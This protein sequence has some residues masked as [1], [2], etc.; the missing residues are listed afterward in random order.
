MNEADR[1]RRLR[2]ILALAVFSILAVRLVTLGAYPLMD[3]TEAR[4]GEIARVML[5]TGNYV[6]PQEIPGIPFWA[7]PPLYAWM[8][9][10]SIRLLGV[11]EFALRLP[12]FF[13][14]LGILAL[15]FVWT[16]TLFQDDDRRRRGRVVPDVAADAAT[17]FAASIAPWLTTALLSTSVLFFVSAGAVMTDPS[18]D[19]TITAMWLAFHQAVV[20]GAALPDRSRRIWGYV[21]F[22]AAGFGMLAKGPVILMYVGGPIALWAIWQRKIAET[23][24]AMPWVSGIALG[25]AIC[26]P[27]YVLAE[28]RTPGYL[29]YFLIG[30]HI[31][32]FLKPGWKGD[33][34]GNPHVEPLGS[35]WLQLAGSLGVA[36]LLAISAAFSAAFSATSSAVSASMGAQ[37]LGSGAK[38]RI[39][40]DRAFLLLC[41]LFP[42]AFFTFA[43]NIIW[44]Y[45]LHSLGP[46]AILLGAWGARA[47]YRAAIWRASVWATIGA[48]WLVLVVAIFAWVPGHVSRHTTAGLVASWNVQRRSEPGPLRYLGPKSPASL[49]FYSRGAAVAEPDLV[50]ALRGADRTH[51]VYLVTGRGVK[52]L[53]EPVVH[54]QPGRPELRHLANNADLTLWKIGG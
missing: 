45:V 23:W 46:I 28:L 52:K 30:E 1:V 29:R 21:F 50:R 14:A 37:R 32:R 47:M 11:N 17:N 33:L 44:T 39:D 25:L 53:L 10:I 38:A 19:L 34:Y 12:S 5:V 43:A 15:C 27:W 6:T 18:L 40:G 41:A 42:V 20:R 49:R 31:M 8:S 35:I 36:T 9:A 4:Y 48:A 7:K 24:K 22:I 16:R 3:T 51:A 54:G 2:W 13:C 26:I